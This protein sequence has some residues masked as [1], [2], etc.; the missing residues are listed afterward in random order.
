MMKKIYK[1][2]ITVVLGLAAS[3]YS[4]DKSKRKP[5]ADDRV[6]GRVTRIQ[7]SH[8][9]GNPS[10]IISLQQESGPGLLKKEVKVDR[11]HKS[12]DIVF[13]LAM[14]AARSKNTEFCVDSYTESSSL[15][16]ASL[17][18]FGPQ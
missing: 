5:S 13:Q 9:P 18:Y 7:A 8:E 10:F 4:A 17:Y 3:G 6:C 16:T 11:D 12:L 14:E 1:P 15:G 2:L